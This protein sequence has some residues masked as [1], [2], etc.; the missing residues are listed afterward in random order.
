MP[1]QELRTKPRGQRRLFILLLA[2]SG[3][4]SPNCALGKD[5]PFPPQILSAKTI[6]VVAHYGLVPSALDPIKGDRFRKDAE[7]VLRASGR[8]TLIDD[9][10]KSDLA[11][12]LVGGYSPGV[13]K[14]HIAIGAIFLGGAQP[15]WSPIPLWISEQTSTRKTSASTALAETF[16][17]QIA[18]AELHG[19]GP[20]AKS[21]QEREHSETKPQDNEKEEALHAPGNLPSQWLRAEILQAKKVMV[22][23]RTD[24]VAGPQ[25]EDKEKS[26]EKELKQWGRFTTLDNPTGADLVFVTVLYQSELELGPTNSIQTY[27]ENLLIFKGGANSPDWNNMPLWTDMLDMPLFGN[28]PGPRMVRRLRKEIEAQEARSSQPAAGPAPQ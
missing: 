15:R 21:D 6:A 1:N 5:K 28:K 27:W 25:G 17:K 23:L 13:F 7:A 20:P 9:P 4:S 8:F 12:L 26:I 11:L 14:D 10:D 2:A 22:L 19:A 24:E 16:L 18:K 3:I